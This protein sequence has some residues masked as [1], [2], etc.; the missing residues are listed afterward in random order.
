MKGDLV[1][2]ALRRNEIGALRFLCHI[3]LQTK[4]AHSHSVRSLCADPIC[5]EICRVQQGFM[6]ISP[7][8][9]DL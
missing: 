8:H 9:P 6:Q 1:L 7:S 3:P 5:S 2:V 4:D